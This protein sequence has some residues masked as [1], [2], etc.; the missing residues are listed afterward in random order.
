MLRA[1]RKPYPRRACTLL[2]QGVLPAG[3]G[4]TWP[5]GPPPVRKVRTVEPDSRSAHTEHAVSLSPRRLA[6]SLC[7]GS[8]LRGGWGPTWPPG[9]LGPALKGS[10]KG[11]L[12]FPTSTGLEQRNGFTK[13]SVKIPSLNDP[14]SP[15]WRAWR[16][17]GHELTKPVQS[18]V[19]RSAWGSWTRPAT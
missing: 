19:E 1:R 3:C 18:S 12:P 6:H 5:T 7:K 15:T 13:A 9:P 10:G 14:D 17:I 16:D 8:S 4:P 2:V 11:L